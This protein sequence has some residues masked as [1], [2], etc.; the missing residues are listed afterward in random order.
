[1][2]PSSKVMMVRVKR[3]FSSLHLEQARGVFPTVLALSLADARGLLLSHLARSTEKSTLSP[4]HTGPHRLSYR[5][6]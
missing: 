3:V 4:G 5:C 1:M 2:P 6:R